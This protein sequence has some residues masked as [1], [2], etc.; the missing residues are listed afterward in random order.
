M[1]WLVR[2]QADGADIVRYQGSLKPG[3]GRLTQAL[4]R[5]ADAYIV[6]VGITP[7]W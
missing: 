3:W 1:A 5:A 4:E 7:C 2:R 6:A